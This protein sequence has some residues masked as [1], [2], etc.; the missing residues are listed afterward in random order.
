MKKPLTGGQSKNYGLS[1]A[2]YIE[3]VILKTAL[4]WRQRKE[5]AGKH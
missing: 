1:D 2:F 3:S 5:Q 4:E